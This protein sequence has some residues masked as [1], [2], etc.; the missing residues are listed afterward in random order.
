MLSY[1]VFLRFTK[2][3]RGS[4]ILEYVSIAERVVEYKKQKTITL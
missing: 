4:A 2:V 3:K 1:D